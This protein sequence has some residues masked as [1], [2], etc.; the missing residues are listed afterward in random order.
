MRN[1][2]YFLILGKATERISHL[3][4]TWRKA[5][6][7]KVSRRKVNPAR[8][9]CR[10]IWAMI[11]L[12]LI[13]TLFSIPVI[14]IGDVISS[15]SYTVMKFLKKDD[16]K[17]WTTFWA[18]F[19]GNFKKTIGLW[20][21]T[22]VETAILV[23]DVLYWLAFLSV[24]KG[25][26]GMTYG[27]VITS[28]V[29]SIILLFLFIMFAC[30]IFPLIGNY[31]NDWKG[32]VK[33]A[34]YLARHEALRSLLYAMIVVGIMALLFVFLPVIVMFIAIGFGVVAL[35]C[36]IIHRSIFQHALSQLEEENA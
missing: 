34:W 19:K 16:T 10:I 30:H 11:Q 5:R 13:I 18:Q 1:T 36:T 26:A 17:I 4:Y 31:E 14:T 6:K 24:G 29:I 33:T 7:N 23:Y 25:P 27:S 8:G 9:M 35:I 12:A 20:L 15:V 22:L 28:L 21:A 2:P 3:I 32:T